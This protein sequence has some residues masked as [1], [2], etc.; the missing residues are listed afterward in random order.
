M[1]STYKIFKTP[2]KHIHQRLFQICAVYTSSLY[3]ANHFYSYLS[4]YLY[5]AAPV[6]TSHLAS[7]RRVPTFICLLDN[8]VGFVCLQ[9]SMARLVWTPNL[10]LGSAAMQAFQLGLVALEGGG[11]WVLFGEWIL[12]PAEN[13]MTSTVETEVKE[14]KE[15]TVEDPQPEILGAKVLPEYQRQAYEKTQQIQQKIVHNQAGQAP[16]TSDVMELDGDS[17]VQSEE[18]V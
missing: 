16:V 12:D 4:G 15:V 8:Q 14:V 1:T 17:D 9:V 3:F 10:D 6:N 5:I 2:H 7:F 13:M 11:L 18:E